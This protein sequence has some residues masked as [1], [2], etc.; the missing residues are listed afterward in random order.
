MF[1]CHRKG[2]IRMKVIRK[3]EEVAEKNL[4]CCPPFAFPGIGRDEE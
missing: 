3:G 1:S 2:V 4:M